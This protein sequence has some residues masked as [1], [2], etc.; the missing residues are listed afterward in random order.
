M[1]NANAM[2][3]RGNK[4]DYYVTP[5]PCIRA[6]IDKT[7]WNFKGLSILDPCCGSGVFGRVFKEYGVDIE[8]Y[9]LS[10]GKDFFDENREFDIIVCNPPYSI[11]DKFIDKALTVAKHIFMIL[12][13]NVGNYNAFHKKYMNNPYFAGKYLMTPK[14]FM[15]TEET[16]NPKRG[17]IS[18]YAWYYWKVR[19]WTEAPWKESFER[20]IDLNNYFKKEK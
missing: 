5:A 11:K 8:E 16:E 18:A 10:Q 1:G 4:N 6:L 17:G 7:Q 13:Y 9:D 15:T 2:G 3:R 14:F 19:K 20:Y 12:P